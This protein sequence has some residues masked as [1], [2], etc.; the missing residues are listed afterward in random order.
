MSKPV[1][2]FQVRPT[3]AHGAQ[4]HCGKFVFAHQ[5]AGEVPRVLTDEE[6]SSAE[7]CCC[8]VSSS[9]HFFEFDSN[10]TPQP[11]VNLSYC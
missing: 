2:F 10:A 11:F 4:N 8:R 1:L 3:S 5:L 7:A 9:L 6:T